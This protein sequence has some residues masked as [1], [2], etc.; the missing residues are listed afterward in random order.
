L[1]AQPSR[2]EAAEIV[3]TPGSLAGVQI[4][5]APADAHMRF[6]ASDADFPSPGFGAAPIRVAAVGL[7][8]RDL[9]AMIAFYRD[10]IGL[11]VLAR[12]R[13]SASLGA[14]GTLLLAL[15]HQP[16]ARIDDPR[17]AGLFHA[18]F[19]M[20][21]RGDLARFLRS[22]ATRGATLTGV[23]DHHVS[24]AVYLDDPEG[25]GVEVYADRPAAQWQR[26]GDAIRI[27]TEPLDLNGLL[28]SIDGDI[29]YPR[30]PAGMRIGHVHLRVGELDAAQRFYGDLV[31]LDVTARMR[32]AVFLSSGGYHHHVAVN[33]WRSAGAPLRDPDRAGLSWVEFAV[34][35]GHHT[36]ILR[37]FTASGID[38]EHP[39]DPWGTRLRLTP[40]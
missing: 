15:E 18:A 24:E 25:N 40:V 21:T 38:R 23:A 6:M 14:D 2:N 19:L 22:L 1:A 31:G 20:P 16:T 36:D 10:T 29:S 34:A 35:E 30:A 12:D 4:V 5:V 3:D 9:D 33:V 17:T 7:R 37:R 27:T 8:V 26:D 28:A 13:A 39:I 32:G 11:E